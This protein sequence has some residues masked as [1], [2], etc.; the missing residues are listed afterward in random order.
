MLTQIIK[1]TPL[2]VWGL[3]AGLITLGVHQSSAR[4]ASL[5]RV[6][7]L[8]AIMCSLS[9][10]GT[11]SA[12]GMVPS[13][14]LAWWL[15]AFGLFALVLV[16]RLPAGTTWDSTG[17]VFTLPA[18]WSTMLLILGIFLTKYAV[19]V[20]LAMKPQLAQAEVFSQTISLLYGAFSGIFLARAARMWRLSLHPEMAYRLVKPVAVRTSWR[21]RAGLALTILLLTPVLLLA[22][23]IGFGGAT[24]PPVLAAMGNVMA[25]R[26][27]PGLPELSTFVA[28]DGGQLAYRAY[29]GGGT[30][31]RVAV[32]VHGS[33][34]DSHAMHG[35]AMALRAKG[36]TAYSLD[37][38]G[39]GASGPRGDVNYVG[40]LD[41]DLVD[42]MRVLR[43]HHANAHVSLI[44]HSSGGGFAL[45]TAGGA[46]H[47]LFDRYLLLAPFLHSDAPTT[48]PNAGGWVRVALPR[49]IGLSILDGL[50]VH[51]FENLPVL[52]FALPAEAGA[53]HTTSYSYRLQLNYRPH[54]DYL[55]DVRGI[56]R[57]VRLLVGSN[58]QM[59]FAEQYAPLLEPLQSQL[60]V[61]VLTGVDHIGMVVDSVALAAVVAEL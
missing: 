42:F 28:R 22:G 43:Q 50:G 41:D 23:L 51:W 6:L 10:L 44:G 17:R 37:V 16:I 33:S 15:G 52:V 55:G 26:S 39:H 24:A 59:F 14:W 25:G 27:Y 7:I 60:K 58:D 48:R 61:K 3:L 29:P 53:T 13:A 20:A 54:L 49:I 31:Q 46:N 21:K 56:T 12:F 5:K 34:G 1:N 9:I 45:R 47:D 38:R 18:A 2:W 35:V 8:P 36:I 57:P 40:Q 4:V 32:L 30:E 11:V 19:G